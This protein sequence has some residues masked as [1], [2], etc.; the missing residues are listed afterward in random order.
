MKKILVPC[1]FSN[2]AVSAFRVALEVATKSK[3]EVHLL[4]VVELP[5]MHDT[6]M[7][8]VLTFEENLLQ[9][10]EEKAQKEFAKLE[11]KYNAGQKVICKVTYGA[12]AVMILNYIN[13]NGIDS[14]VMGSKG[15]AGM[16]EVLV[17]SNAEKIVR[18]AEVPVVVVKK[19]IKADAIKNIVFPNTLED[20][21]EALLARV[22]ALQSFFKA[23]LHV[24][25]IN[26]PTNF[27]RGVTALEQLKK[28]AKRFML[29]NYTL[30][31]YNDTYEEVGVINFAD[32]INAD[33]IAM[34]THGR[35]GLNHLLA[36]SI[37]EDVVNHVEEMPIW[38]YATRGE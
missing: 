24:V 35:R 10:L 2:Q 15:A 30:N 11:K 3:G 5:L 6:L 31:I 21:Q 8:P 20:D 33:M 12:T 38:T 18:Q 26:T 36:G 23:T 14:V 1:D 19:Y 7:G 32:E 34:G 4:H 9:E 17:G 25:Y 22:K 13:E 16:Q 37:A 28:F 27:T 29:K